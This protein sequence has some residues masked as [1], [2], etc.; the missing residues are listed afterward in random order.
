MR[1][2][3][4]HA[5]KLRMRT[6]LCPLPLAVVRRDALQHRLVLRLTLLAVDCGAVLFSRAHYPH[7]VPAN[8]QIIKCDVE[9][10]NRKNLANI[11]MNHMIAL[12][13]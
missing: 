2:R 11:A 10:F 6:N 12:G 8:L 3:I 5:T 4:Q 13:D 1:K 7:V 9:G